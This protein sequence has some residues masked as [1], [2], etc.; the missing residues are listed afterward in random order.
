M[1]HRL[2]E[3]F[4]RPSFGGFCNHRTLISQSGIVIARVAYSN[5]PAANIQPP[6]AHNLPLKP[7][8]PEDVRVPFGQL[9]RTDKM[10]QIGKT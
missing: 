4:D 5:E 8:H 7:Q 9:F 3:S 10:I 6:V 2:W 1:Q